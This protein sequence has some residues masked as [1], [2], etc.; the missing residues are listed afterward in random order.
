MLP[1][2]DSNALAF[3]YRKAVIGSHKLSDALPLSGTYCR[4]DIGTDRISYVRT[5][6]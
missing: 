5:N 3:S 6:C 2:G 1:S 4:P